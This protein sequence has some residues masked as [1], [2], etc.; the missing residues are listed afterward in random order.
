MPVDPQIQTLLEAARAAGFRPAHT[1]NVA[2]ARQREVALANRAFPLAEVANVEHRQ[3]P[4]PAGQIIV[5]LY[6]PRGN[7]PHPLLIYFHGGGW[8]VGSL[9]SVDPLCRAFCH[10]AGCMVMSVDYRLAPEHKFPAASDDC[11]TATEWAL[12]NAATLGV[13]PARIAVGGDSAGGNLAAVTALRLRDKGVSVLSAQLLIYP[14]TAYPIP[15]TRSQLECSEGYGLSHEE[16]LWYADHYVAH[17]ED[18]QN[19]YAFPLLAEDLSGLPTAFVLTAEYDV[20]RDEGDEY[21]ARLQEAGVPT[22]HKRYTGMTHGF[23]SMNGRVD[24]AQVALD[25]IV[26]W[27]RRKLTLK[28]VG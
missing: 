6:T 21:A 8:V 25:E 22:H 27:L 19:P 14:A 3:V 20:L 5:R 24:R 2:E 13:H 7:R 1:L 28:S 16:S 10:G 12:A 26:S 9:E 23:L 17:P 18:A 11:L 4:G 15:P